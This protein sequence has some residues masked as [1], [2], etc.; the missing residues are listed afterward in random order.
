MPMQPS[1][2]VVHI[3]LKGLMESSVRFLVSVAAEEFS[4]EY[5]IE[6][7]LYLEL[8]FGFSP[9]HTRSWRSG[10]ASSQATQGSR[11]HMA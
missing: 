1:T 4:R 6:V 8:A 2:Q 11:K 5:V 3:P 10:P 7:L 9:A